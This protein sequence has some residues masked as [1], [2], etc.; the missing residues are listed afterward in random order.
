MR[1]SLLLAAVVLCVVPASAAAQTGG[2]AAPEGS[3]GAEYGAPVPQKPSA[4]KKPRRAP[5]RLV[6]SEFTIA[7][8]SLQPGG[9]PAQI[10]W[11]VDG[12]V[13]RVRVRVDILQAGRRAPVARIR[14]GW[15]KTGVRGVRTWAVP[16][17][18]M[19]AGEY[20]ARLHAVDDAG[21]TLARTAAS[22]GR[23]SLHVAAP[24]PP[25]PAA[26]I[27]VVS[28]TFPVQGPWSF[29]GDE[30]RFGAQRDGHIHQGQDVIAAEGTP[31]ITPRAGVVYW[32]AFQSGGA[33]HYLVI[34]G[35]D[36]RDYVFMHLREASPLSRENA[37]TAGQVIGAV[38]NTGRS[39]GAH[40]HFEIWPNGWYAKDSE[41]IDPR[42]DLEAWAASSGAAPA[43]TPSPA[44]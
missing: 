2:A 17:G 41:P 39:D 28:G 24:P 20:V 12:R 10:S 43:A 38:G 30:A 7:P 6:A 4:R 15:K 23:S 1:P 22:S 14:M 5:V 26:P 37:V 25:A 9:P 35:D 33:G 29:G 40:L 8:D 31:L 13:R 44:P 21:R 36:G 32:K 3:G 16:A 11:R 19:P 42:P 18:L 27:T 34:R